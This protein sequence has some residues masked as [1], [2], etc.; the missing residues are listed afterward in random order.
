[1][2]KHLSSRDIVLAALEEFQWD[3]A[4]QD[5]LIDY[6]QKEFSEVAPKGALA[7]NS[8]TKGMSDHF[9]DGLVARSNEKDRRTVTGRGQDRHWLV[10]YMPDDGAHLHKNVEHAARMEKA[11]KTHA[12]YAEANAARGK[13]AASFEDWVAGFER[14]KDTYT[15][16]HCVDDLDEMLDA[17]GDE[18]HALDFETTAFTPEEGEVRLVQ[19]YGPAGWWVVDFF[20]VG[21]DVL[22]RDDL[23][24]SFT[25]YQDGFRM[26]AAWFKDAPWIVFNASFEMRWFEEA[27][28]EPITCWDVAFLRKAV[29]GGGGFSLAQALKDA[30]DYD[31]PKEEQASDWSAEPLTQSQLDYAADDAI[32]TWKLWNHWRDRADDDQMRAF[33]LLND[34]QPAVLEMQRAGMKLDPKRHAEV[35]EGWQRLEKLRVEAIREVISVDDIENLN[36]NSQWSDYFNRILPDDYLDIWPKGE[37]TGL[38]SFSKG[39]MKE[40][41]GVFG[42]SPIGDVLRQKQELVKIRHWISNFGWNLIR[43][44][45]NDPNGRI[46]ARYNIA[47]A[48]TCRFS[49]SSPNLQQTP[50]DTELLGEFVSVRQ[51]FIAHLGNVLASL[52]YS[53]IE[54]RVLAL[55]SGDQQLLEDVVDGDVHLE[56]GSFWQGRRLDK[57][58]KADKEWRSKAKGVS[59]GIIYGSTELGLAGTMGVSIAKAEEL[60]G[61]WGDR[62]PKA[63]AYRYDAQQQAQEDGGYL[64]VVD[65]GTIYMGKKVKSTQAANY[66]V[67]RGALSV[68]AKAIARHKETLDSWRDAGHPA[69]RETS[70]LSTIHDALI[71]ETKPEHG[72][73]VLRA[74]ARDMTDGYL[75]IFPGAPTHR[76]LEGGVGPSWGELEEHEIEGA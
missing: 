57:S 53:G 24:T 34:M 29:D 48:R 9:R 47:Q 12:G 3:G 30:F 52:D 6:V 62:Y 74:M 61:F 18:P 35:V 40:I 39:A 58:I 17:I 31:M 56:V 26:T 63:M 23:T 13:G 49:C 33:D 44:A 73:E 64:R 69:G 51:S 41:I 19:I 38:L 10:R 65:G 14:A 55:L 11:R 16:V 1:M 50:R 28:D 21:Y 8:I 2:A 71:D 67:Q 15:T 45:E 37:K 46:H 5:D 72:E 32:W 59:F 4:I 25:R 36:S 75:D 68:M 76:L 54:L 43:I 66:P 70:F 22:D 7:A 27:T 42:D 60:M 20:D